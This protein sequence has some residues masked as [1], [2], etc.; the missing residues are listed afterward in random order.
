MDGY[1]VIT[2]ACCS[3]PMYASLTTSP[4]RSKGRCFDCRAAC[5]PGFA[6]RA[7]TNGHKRKIVTRN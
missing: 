5:Q 2:C 6:C 4:T 7:S 3:R 1:T